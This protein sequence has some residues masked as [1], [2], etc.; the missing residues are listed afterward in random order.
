MSFLQCRLTISGRVF[1]VQ[2]AS[3]SIGG[4]VFG[5]LTSLF[6]TPFGFVLIMSGQAFITSGVV[7]LI[8][9]AASALPDH[10]IN[11]SDP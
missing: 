11:P 3:K 9:V 5:G 4:V 7:T 2:R 10:R 6:A 1:S 8:Y